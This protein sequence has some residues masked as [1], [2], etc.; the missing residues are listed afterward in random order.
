MCITFV[1]VCADEMSQVT[2]CLYFYWVVVGLQISCT[3]A[4]KIA[5]LETS[6]Q[7][8]YKYKC[9][10]MGSQPARPAGVFNNMHS[11]T[12]GRVVGADIHV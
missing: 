5:K 1:Q 8:W 10:F 12:I 3:T 11:P 9:R 4:E 6:H 7:L 2:Y